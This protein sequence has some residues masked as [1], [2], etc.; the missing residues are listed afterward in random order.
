VE[1][2]QT[3]PDVA[4]WTIF[5]S[6]AFVLLITPGPSIMYVMA[7]AIAQGPH[8]AI[9]SAV[10]LALGDLLQVVAT[11]IGVSALLASA[12]AIFSM[13]KFA[14]A[15]YL[16]VLGTLTLVG[17][18]ARAASPIEGNLRPQQPAKRSLILQGFLALNPKTALFFLAFLPQ[19]VDRR[20]GSTSAQILTFGLAFVVLGFLTNSL[21]GCLAGK[22]G[23]VAR[24]NNAF[25]AIT[26]FA[27]GIILIALGVVAAYMPT[28][29]RSP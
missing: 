23:D 16:V 19:F 29:Q 25:Q 24:S 8:A 11:A 9:L 18:G 15:V 17:K 3:V 22:L 13:L 28:P 27:S 1:D 4:H 12:S 14:G 10:G 2:S 5:L 21:F 7:R 6:A 26:R 20:A